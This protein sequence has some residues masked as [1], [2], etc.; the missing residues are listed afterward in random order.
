MKEARAAVTR[1]VAVADG[2]ATSTTEMPPTLPF[3][4]MRAHAVAADVS[5]DTW[6]TTAAETHLN[7]AMDILRAEGGRI[8]CTYAVCEADMLGW[9]LAQ[10]HLLALTGRP[11]P[12]L[13]LVDHVL[14]EAKE[15][16]VEAE[17][18]R[19]DC[20]DVMAFA[21]DEQ[22]D[23]ISA[24]KALP[25]VVAIRERAVAVDD[26]DRGAWLA[27][28]EALLALG[29]T[30]EDDAPAL[31]RHAFV[32]ARVI[33]ERLT[34]G[35]RPDASAPRHLLARALLG[36]ATTDADTSAARALALEAHGI[37][38]AIPRWEESAWLSATMAVAC[39]RLGRVDEA[40]PLVRR[41]IEANWRTRSVREL[42]EATGLD[43][44]HRHVAGR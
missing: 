25:E 23:T 12:A 31:A 32:R 9:M 34:S 29:E 44:G 35:A 38:G 5:V 21:M 24:V 43:A 39:V 4:R 26:T 33:G 2:L 11:G 41:M 36:L 20:L 13:D 16:G 14:A 37:I 10:A 1:A 22:G 8:G 6:E 40:R 27:L 28:G 19:A 18:L 3:E 15:L 42:A 7:R 30:V 17:A